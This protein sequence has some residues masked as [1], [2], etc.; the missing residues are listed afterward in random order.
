MRHCLL[1]ISLLCVSQAFGQN[2]EK[3]GKED[4]V[5]V[6]GGMRSNF[7]FNHTLNQ[8]QFR[9]PLSWVF[10][11]NLTVT[12]ADLALPFTFS[13]SNTGRS[14]TQPFNMTAVHPTYKKWKSHI[15]ITSMTFSPYTY[16]GIN[17][18][19][20]GLE[21]TP[22]KWSFKAFGGRLKKAIEF[23]ADANNIN[24]VSYS[25]MGFGF[26]TEYK[27]KT[28]GTE[29]LLFKAYDNPASLDFYH[30]NPELTAKDNMVVS[31]KGNVSL[32]SSLKLN[33]E[34]ATS[35]LTRDIL[36][37][38][39]SNA[40][41]LGG[42]V[43]GNRTT[44]ASQAYNASLD[45]RFKSYGVGV[46]YE[47]IAPDYSTLGAVYFNNDLENITVNPSFSLWKNKINLSMST[48]YQRNNLNAQNASESKRWIGNASLSAQLI[49]GMSLNLNYSNMSSFSRRNPLADP[50]YTPLGD[51]LNYYQTSV[52]L[53]TSLS[54]AFGQKVKQSMSATASYSQSQ[55][56]TGRLEDAAAFGF[57]VLPENDEVPVDVYT[58]MFAHNIQLPEGKAA[59][60]WMVNANYTDVL[61][62]TNLFVGPGLNA[63]TSVNDKKLSINLG[64]NYNSQFTNEELSNH[65]LNFRTGLSYK[66]DFLDKKY[67]TLSMNLNGNWTNRFSVTSAPNTQNITII[68]NLAYQF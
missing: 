61:G 30:N 63:S 52:N 43:Q 2:L 60:G 6:S 31:L 68:A 17:F 66:P 22:E 35:I 57:N 20:A 12:I 36:A 32:F 40:A 27:G 50:F 21:Y 23:D 34:I 67:G 29:L 7:V 55:N 37:D 46:K 44:T 14:F 5:Q 15:G 3:I 8:E 9:D 48:G 25:R 39:G 13:Y 47:R 19:G 49:K 16:S 26:G 64:T 10:S 41:F 56:I 65:V 33:A 4:M 1:L 45:Y 38:Q 24:T 51:T 54:Y 58:G 18:T 53:S 42:L 11:G 28:F 62:S 59:L